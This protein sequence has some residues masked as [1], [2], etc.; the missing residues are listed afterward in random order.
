YLGRKLQA[1]VW[2]RDQPCGSST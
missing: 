2:K 1:Y